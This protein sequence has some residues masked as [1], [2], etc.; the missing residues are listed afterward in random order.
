MCTQS[1]TGENKLKLK[2][3]QSN[4]EKLNAEAGNFKKQYLCGGDDLVGGSIRSR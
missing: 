1:K 4:V 2:V 3:K